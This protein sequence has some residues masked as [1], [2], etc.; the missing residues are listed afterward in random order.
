ME[1][2]RQA[3]KQP[4]N[5]K[6][7][8]RLEGMETI[9]LDMHLRGYVTSPTRLEGMETKVMKVMFNDSGGSPTRLEGMET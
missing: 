8:T 6:S 9:W 1:T 5:D 2:Q 3:I 7:P 4:F